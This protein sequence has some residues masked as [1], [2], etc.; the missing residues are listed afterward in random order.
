MYLYS[1]S[2]SEKRAF[3]LEKRDT[4]IYIYIPRIHSFI[5]C[6][7]GRRRAPLRTVHLRCVLGVRD[8]RDDHRCEG[9][10]R[11]DSADVPA[12]L[13][14]QWLAGRKQVWNAWWV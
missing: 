4:I 7:S 8:R 3:P 13:A 5:H 11:A 1:K 6:L 9:D 2:F 14:A 10:R 12:G